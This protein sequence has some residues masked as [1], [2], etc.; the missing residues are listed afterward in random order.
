[1]FNTTHIY[2]EVNLY[3]MFQRKVYTKNFKKIYSSY[4]AHGKL[5]A[6]LNLRRGK[7]RVM[8]NAITQ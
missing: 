6:L 4:P 3:N 5:H 8:S 2:K 1:M 7:E